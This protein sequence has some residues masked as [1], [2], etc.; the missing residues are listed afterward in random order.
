MPK[1][2]PG[3]SYLPTTDAPDSPSKTMAKAAPSKGKP[4][5]QIVIWM[6]VICGLAFVINA[7]VSRLQSRTA[8]LS[9]TSTQNQL[10]SKGTV[11]LPSGVKVS[12]AVGSQGD[13]QCVSQH[14]ADTPTAQCQAFCNQKF[15]KFHC[16]WCKC[17]AC[18]FCPKGGEAIEEA[19]KAT[20]TDAANAAAGVANGAA[21]AAAE[22]YQ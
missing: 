6:A 11:T 18:D 22:C 14:K 13:T 8:G 20:P 5:R 21:D 16:M 7:N 4:V 15:M 1:K 17:R 3:G 10:A 12:T 19:A 2:S 9:S